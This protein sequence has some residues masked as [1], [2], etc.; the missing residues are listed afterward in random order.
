[1]GYP[2][3]VGR[4]RRESLMVQRPDAPESDHECSHPPPQGLT[5]IEGNA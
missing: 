1:M 5:P 3:G 2:R 4:N